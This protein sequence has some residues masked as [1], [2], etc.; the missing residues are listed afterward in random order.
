M[1]NKPK[2]KDR[3]YY[4][5]AFRIIGDFGAS[6]AIPVVAL[7]MVGQWLDGKY[8]RS[9]LFTVLG[10]VIAALITAKIIYRKAKMYGEKYKNIE[11]E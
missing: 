1:E 11:K 2:N 4:L 8:G 6:I 5:L 10:F 3:A 9:P 7:A